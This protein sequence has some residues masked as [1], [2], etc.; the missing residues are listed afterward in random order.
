M[1]ELF[2]VRTRSLNGLRRDPRDPLPIL[3]GIAE[4]IFPVK[5]DESKSRKIFKLLAAVL[6]DMPSEQQRAAHK[7]FDLD[8]GV[9]VI[10]LEQR[11]KNA[12]VQ[13]NPPVER[14]EAFSDNR[15][16][17]GQHEQRLIMAVGHATLDWHQRLRPRIRPRLRRKSE[18]NYACHLGWPYVERP[19]LEAQFIEAIENSSVV[20]LVGGR[21][22]GKTRLAQELCV[23]HAENNKDR[24]VLIRDSKF[25][26][27][28]DGR[29]SPDLIAALRER[30]INLH[31]LNSTPEQVFSRFVEMLTTEVAPTFVII[32]NAYHLDKIEQLLHPDAKS[33]FVL[34]STYPI[35]GPPV[36]YVPQMTDKQATEFVRNAIDGV[37]DE[38]IRAVISA[39]GN[40]P[41]VIEGQCW[42]LEHEESRKIEE[43][44]NMLRF[45]PLQFFEMTDSVWRD[46]VSTYYEAVYDMLKQQDSMAATLLELLSHFDGWSFDVSWLAELFGRLVGLPDWSHRQALNQSAGRLKERGVIVWT[47]NAF[48]NINCLTQF[49]IRD[50]VRGRKEE[51]LDRIY[52]VI[53]SRLEYYSRV[54]DI[55]NYSMWEKVWSRALTSGSPQWNSIRHE[56]PAIQVEPVPD[57]SQL[58]RADLPERDPVDVAAKYFAMQVDAFLKH[59]NAVNHAIGNAGRT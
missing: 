52:S 46:R 41:G 1:G 29:H 19:E 51:L 40:R 11:Q 27:L 35:E 38:Q 57:Q 7:L 42:L 6:D 44:A 23:R 32:D 24:V 25:G 50:L 47:D 9:T 37:T 39:A 10:T 13:L 21:R 49:V 55:S 59:L 43:V 54:N 8:S 3:L 36:I 22:V 58:R 18:V 4:D 20:V 2:T 33:T 30:S 28:D 45:S 12:G 53:D 26:G 14:P 15:E 31:A 56:A 34:T 5:E 48:V 17:A 16:K